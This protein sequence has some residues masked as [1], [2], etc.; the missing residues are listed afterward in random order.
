MDSLLLATDSPSD[1]L[2]DLERLQGTWNFVSGIRPAQLLIAGDHFTMKFSNGDLYM[3][4][5]RLDPTQDPAAMDVEAATRE[6]EAWRAKHEADYRREWVTIAG[7]HFL[8]P[9]AHT[10]G[11]APSN[12]IVLPA[13][14]P[15]TVRAE[16]PW[17]R[18]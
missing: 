16:T 6:S 5:L 1:A 13:S 4:T 9:G 10:A 12:D 8:E 17:C 11:S 3:G 18:S 2:R 7:L 15:P 14:T